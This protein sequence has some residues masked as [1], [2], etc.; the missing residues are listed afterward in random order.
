MGLYL[1]GVPFGLFFTIWGSIKAYQAFTYKAEKKQDRGIRA[2][3]LAL[4]AVAFGVAILRT[5]FFRAS[6]FSK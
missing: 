2:G 3:I 4:I 5:N 1:L 6:G